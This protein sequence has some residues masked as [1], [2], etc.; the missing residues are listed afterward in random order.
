MPQFKV[1]VRP[2][3]R[4]NDKRKSWAKLYDC[5]DPSCLD[6]EKLSP[7]FW[8]LREREPWKRIAAELVAQANAVFMYEAAH[9]AICD[10]LAQERANRDQRETRH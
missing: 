10:A 3:H 4:L 7:A 1:E 8:W 6:P 2:I 5:T 9:R